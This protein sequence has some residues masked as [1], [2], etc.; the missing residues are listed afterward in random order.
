[1]TA[2]TVQKRTSER[3]EELLSG[4]TKDQM[5]FVIVL[6][7]CASKK[8]AAQAIGLSPRTVYQWPDE[9]D[10]VLPFVIGPDNENVR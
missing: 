6:Q 1:M 8:E 5:R 10:Q 3:L 9:V 7:E 4:L 2:K